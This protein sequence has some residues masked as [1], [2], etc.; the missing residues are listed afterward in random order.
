MIPFWQ[1]HTPTEIA[2][3]TMLDAVW[4]I[5]WLIGWCIALWQYFAAPAPPQVERFTIRGQEYVVMNLRSPLLSNT[6]NI[7]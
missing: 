6:V 3:E 2:L 4:C 7:R 1:S 5:A